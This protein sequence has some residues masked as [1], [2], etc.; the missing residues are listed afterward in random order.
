MTHPG[1]LPI[2]HNTEI[3]TPFLVIFRN[4][5]WPNPLRVTSFLSPCGCLVICYA[6]MHSF[7]AFNDCLCSMHCR[8][9]ARSASSLRYQLAIWPRNCI[10]SGSVLTCASCWQM[11]YPLSPA[12]SFLRSDSDTC[13]GFLLYI[14][15]ICNLQYIHRNSGTIF[16]KT[17]VSWQN[18]CEHTKAAPR[19]FILA[20]G[21]TS[22]WRKW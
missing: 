7:H 18:A 6:T 9:P 11:S 12:F 13:F 1:I 4:V 5:F 15:Q 20:L 3:P 14:Y 22:K 10:T 16:D 2:L 8:L 19:P 21:A 17:T